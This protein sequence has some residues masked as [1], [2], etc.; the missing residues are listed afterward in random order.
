MGWGSWPAVVTCR[1]LAQHPDLLTAAALLAA[2]G[3]GRAVRAG[4]RAARTFN[5]ETSVNAA[6][7][8]E[9]AHRSARAPSAEPAVPPRQSTGPPSAPLRA[10]GP[11]DGWP[12][13]EGYRI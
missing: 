9:A 11:T 5:T 8:P 6:R 7:G 3:S 2:A 12:A 13:S 4:L 1:R 10:L